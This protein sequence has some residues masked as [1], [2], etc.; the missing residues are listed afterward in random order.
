LLC[1]LAVRRT[2][3]AAENTFALRVTG[4][5]ALGPSGTGGRDTRL[6]ESAD[7]LLSALESLGL[8]HAMTAAAARALS[9][10]PTD[11]RFVEVADEVQ[12]PFERLESA[13]IYLF[14][15]AS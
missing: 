4:K 6:F 8:D 12:I 2:Q 5:T 1:N 3:D 9:E 13:D 11:D 14:D 10:P 15:D 7:A